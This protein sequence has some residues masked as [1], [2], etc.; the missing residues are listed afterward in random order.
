M[1]LFLTCIEKSEKGENM[2]VLYSYFDGYQK[3]EPD[4]RMTT[5]SIDTLQSEPTEKYKISIRNQT[6]SPAS[7]GPWIFPG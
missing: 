6:R 2:Q 5:R 1:F 4:L 3:D 7:K